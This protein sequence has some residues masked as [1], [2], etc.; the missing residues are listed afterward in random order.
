MTAEHLLNSLNRPRAS[1]GFAP[2]ES[3][4]QII[5]RLHLNGSNQRH[6][7]ND[8]RHR[9]WERNAPRVVIK[10]VDRSTG[11]SRLVL[12]GV[13]RDFRVLILPCS[14]DA[15]YPC[16]I[17]AWINNFLDGADQISHV[18]MDPGVVIHGSNLQLC[19]EQ[20]LLSFVPPGG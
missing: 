8:V 10:G 11:R 17:L 4:W 14:H 1:L 7:K 9:T 16:T 2:P 6:A 18:Q 13:D 5:A 19:L 15:C 12:I 20:S 3:V